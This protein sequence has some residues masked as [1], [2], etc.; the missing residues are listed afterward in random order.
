MRIHRWIL[1]GFAV[2]ATL[3]GTAHAQYRDDTRYDN[4]YDSRYDSRYDQRYPQQYQ[5]QQWQAN[6][7]TWGNNDRSSNNNV[8]WQQAQTLR[9]RVEQVATPSHGGFSVERL[10]LRTDQGDMVPVFIGRQ[11]RVSDLNLQPGTQLEV[12]GYQ[13]QINGANAFIANQVRTNNEQVIFIQRNEQPTRVSGTITN[14]RSLSRS[15]GTNTILDIRTDSG[16]NVAVDAGRSDALSNVNLNRNMRVEV[17]GYMTRENEHD[18]LMAKQIRLDSGAF[19]SRFNSTNEASEQNTG[20]KFEEFGKKI[21]NTFKNT[22][23]K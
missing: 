5:N 21:E 11:D 13:T 2:S 14:T 15:G 23:G 19:G 3:A 17:I 20:D 22:F 4:R 1:G 16:N 7:Q 6:Q 12:T 9:G 18:L 8:G 10:T